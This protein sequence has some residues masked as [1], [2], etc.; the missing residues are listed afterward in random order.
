MRRLPV[1]LA[2]FVIGLAV[3]Y[4][5]TRN[6]PER[7]IERAFDRVEKQVSKRSEEGNL[8]TVGKVRGLLEMFHDP[9]E[10]RAEPFDFA[11]RDPRS[12][13]GAV[14]QYRAGAARVTMSVTEREIHIDKG[15]G[16]ATS[17]VTATF[18]GGI[19]DFDRD[20]YRF[21]VNWVELDGEWKI[22][23]VDLLEVL[24]R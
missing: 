16:R 2:L 14:Q 9:F 8:V 11:T 24:A 10:F 19:S 21:Q 22:E 7:Q 5:S 13:A 23:F 12:L 20:S 6:S 1:V 15:A 4:F 3:G 17:Y 18:S